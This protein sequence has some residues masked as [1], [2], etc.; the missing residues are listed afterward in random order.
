MAEIPGS[1]P[2]I[3]GLDPG[4]RRYRGRGGTCPAGRFLRKPGHVGS[5][6]PFQPGALHHP[7]RDDVL[8]QL[9]SIKTDA[10]TLLQNARSL[11]D[12]NLVNSLIDAYNTVGMREKANEISQRYE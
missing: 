9:D 1:W 7:E 11:P 4:E 8:S 12:L 3:P 6:G 2:G 5:N 10:E